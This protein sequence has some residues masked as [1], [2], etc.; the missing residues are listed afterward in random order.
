MVRR[1]LLDMDGVLVDFLQ[2]VH[3]HYGWEYGPA[4]YPYKPGQRDVIPHK[5]HGM[6]EAE[7]EV[8]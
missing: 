1:C 2:G 8:K 6:T 4:N 7:F 5:K 3:D